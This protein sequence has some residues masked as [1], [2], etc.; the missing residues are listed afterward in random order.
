MCNTANE[1]ST[2]RLLT[3]LKCYEYFINHRLKDDRILIKVLGKI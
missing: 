2:F 1:L 3:D